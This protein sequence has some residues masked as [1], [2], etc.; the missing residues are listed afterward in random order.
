MK[1]YP[2]VLIMLFLGLSAK[3]QTVTANTGSNVSKE[4]AQLAL[5]FQNKVRKDVSCPPLKWDIELAAYAQEWANYLSTQNNCQI[6]HRGYDPSKNRGENIFW[7]S[8]KDYTTLD[9]AESWYSEINKYSNRI[10]T[11][12]NYYSTGHYTQMVWKDTKKVGIGIAKCK[13][14]SII[15]VANY[16]PCGNVIGQKPY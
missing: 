11:E 15:I 5:D 3:A 10:V 12:Q 9:A 4:D 6:K 2:I 1:T 13:D 7:G 14:G 16:Y 8:G